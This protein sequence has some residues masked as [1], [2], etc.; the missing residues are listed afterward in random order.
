MGNYSCACDFC[1]SNNKSE[2]NLSREYISTEKNLNKKS[3]ISIFF[4]NNYM[5][6]INSKSKN[7]FPSTTK[8]KNINKNISPSSKLHQ[9]KLSNKEN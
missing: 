9:I 1:H 3:N 4:Q 8:F 7:I 6:D 2:Q 5:L